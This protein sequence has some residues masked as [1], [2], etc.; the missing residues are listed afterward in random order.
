MNIYIMD[1]D[2]IKKIQ[3]EAHRKRISRSHVVR[4]ILKTYFERDRQ[5][6]DHD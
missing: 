2:L 5:K 4:E 6:D 3:N 1:A